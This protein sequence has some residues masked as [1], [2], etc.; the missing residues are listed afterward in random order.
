MEKLFKRKRGLR[1]ITAILCCCLIGL[2]FSSVAVFAGNSEVN[3]APETPLAALADE[4]YVTV[5]AQAGVSA[6]PAKAFAFTKA[7]FEAIAVEGS[8]SSMHWRTGAWNI[9]TS[10]R[11][12]ELP[13]IFDAAGITVANDDNIKTAAAD[14]FSA[15]NTWAVMN[16]GYFY[17]GAGAGDFE[18]AGAEPVIPALGLTYAGTAV[19]TT[20]A[21]AATS[22]SERQSD[23]G[24]PR[25]IYGNLPENFTSANASLNAGNRFTS[26]VTTITVIFADPAPTAVTFDPQN[27]EAVT[28]M[29]VPKGSVATPPADPTL[30]GFTF[31]GWFTSDTPSPA[32]EAVDVANTAIL[33]PVTFYAKW[34]SQ[35][36]VL[37]A[38]KEAKT[39]EIDAATKDL[40][41]SD[42]TAE[43]WATLKSAVD[44]AKAAVNAATSPEEA[45]AVDLSA[46]NAAINSLV[47]ATVVAKDDKVA[48][49][50][51][52]ISGAPA[53]FYPWKAAD[54]THTLL[55]SATVSPSTASDKTVTWKADP[56]SIATINA[57]TGL[58]TFT[59]TEG[60]V[61]VTATSKSD[62]AVSAYKDIKVAKNVT[63]ISTPLKKV[64]I[65]KGKSY[66]VPYGAYDGSKAIKP[67]LTWKSSK[68]KIAKVSQT[69][70]VTI[71]KT[72]KKGKATIT[73]TAANGKKLTITVNVSSKAV[74]LKKMTVKA[75]AT[76]KVKATKFMTIKLAQTKATL[77]K[78]TFKSSKASGLSVDKAGKLTAIKKGKYTITIKIGSV[79]VKKKITV[80]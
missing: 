4:P 24:C 53:K 80:K 35:A 13:T 16:G 29:D 10:T 1:A 51:I 48:A 49:T 6:T 9:S 73:A 25:L 41:E 12:V 70:K 11:Y 57:A 76:M 30:E 60:T 17:P 63:K 2:L 37:A 3:A 55:L 62:P 74:K 28:T 26:G 65:Q 39:S 58:L 59:G 66:V 42:Y 45:A 64:Y 22:N 15:T 77:T 40:K 54:K 18:Q 69:G 72:V 75:P 34:E 5:Y 20:A 21:D 31:K 27:G 44:A 56:A 32:D 23:S 36:E 61:R 19:T 50:G 79:T 7:E 38:A 52:A 67:K 46:V 14:G 71:P 43:S 78:V 47:R 8:V 68:P 33:N